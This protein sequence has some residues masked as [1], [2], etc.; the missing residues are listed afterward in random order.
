M[1]LDSLLLLSCRSPFLDDS[2]I[3][4]PMANLY[5][6]SYVN[7]E[8]P[9]VEVT[10]GDD[11]YDLENLD[12]FEPF[13][14]IGIS[15]MTPQREEASKILRA[16]K[17]RFPRKIVIAGGPH[18]KH[19]A[20]EIVANEPYD[21]IIP[22]DGEKPLVA[23]LRGETDSLPHR[24][25]RMSLSVDPN[26]DRKVSTP[27]MDDITDPRIL[28]FSM[29][30][31]DIL[32]QPRPD[33]T[34]PN[35]I[36]VVRGYNYTLGGKDSTTMMCA[37]GC[38]ELCSFCEDARTAIRWSSMDSITGQLDDIVNLGYE[39]VY[40]FDDL[41]AIALKKIQPICEE[42]K[43]RDLIFRCNAQ[44]RYF[45]KWGDDMAVLLSESGCH[46]IAFGAESGSQT[47]LDN[48]NKRTTVEANYETIRVANKYGIVVKAFILLGLPGETDE[49][50]RDTEKMIQYLME[51]PVNDFG[52]YVYYP[53]KGTQIRDALDRGESPGISMLVEEG[54]GAY[55]QKGGNTETGVIRTDALSSDE[56]SDFRD[57][58]V[59]TYRPV[60]HERHWEK[61]HDTHMETNV[62]YDVG[63]L[64]CAAPQAPVTPKSNLIQIKMGRKK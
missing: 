58:L 52:C 10:L 61:F 39:G 59:D 64:G 44:A 21:W 7:Q 5:L 16:I 15:I 1:S 51:N 42:I 4:A 46:E 33:R 20:K 9:D 41:F 28:T 30:R 55:G 27:V 53:Y 23:I 36:E 40:L 37:R 32:E 12:Y 48:I 35:A 18:V 50:L 17:E 11:S 62:E 45:T 49:T 43:K 54:L 34:S 25:T 13:D 14:A 38:V 6:K 3:Y 60:S 47:I 29:S 57:Y 22:K 26:D 19:Y 2:K 8:V 24:Y 56:L 31:D 63:S